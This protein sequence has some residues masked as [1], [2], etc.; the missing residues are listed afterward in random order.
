MSQAAVYTP[1]YRPPG[2]PCLICGTT[3]VLR[4]ARGRKSGKPC[5]LLI[6]PSD[7]RHFRAFITD[8][9]FVR[10]VCNRLEDNGD[11]DSHGDEGGEPPVR[12]A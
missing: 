8:Q 12:S 7:P 2:I 10:Q 11:R 6:C 1:A 4:P 3:L 5:L 9:E